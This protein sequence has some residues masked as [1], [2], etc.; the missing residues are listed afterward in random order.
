MLLDRP[1]VDHVVPILDGDVLRAALTIAK[2][3]ASITAAD[4][5]LCRTWRTARLLLQGVALAAELRERV[6]QAAELASEL[7]HPGSG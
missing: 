3:G 6:R 7:Q 4:Q 2:P 5:R 1:D